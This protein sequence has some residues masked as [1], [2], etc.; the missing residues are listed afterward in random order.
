[1]DGRVPTN[2]K[3]EQLYARSQHA[4]YEGETNSDD[5]DY[6]HDKEDWLKKIFKLIVPAFIVWFLHG[7]LPLYAVFLSY[8]AFYPTRAVLID[9]MFGTK[10][11]GDLTKLEIASLALPALVAIVSLLAFYVPS[12]AFL[13]AYLPAAIIV[14]AGF[15]FAYLYSSSSPELIPVMTAITMTAVMFG[16]GLLVEANFVLAASLIGS[17]VFLIETTFY[18]SNKRDYDWLFMLC[19]F[20]FN[21]VSTI[22]LTLI[23]GLS[24]FGLLP[25][26][27]LTKPVFATIWA[28]FILAY[29]FTYFFIEL[30]AQAQEG[31]I[32]YYSTFLLSLCLV[33]GYIINPIFA[34]IGIVVFALEYYLKYQGEESY[35]TKKSILLYCTLILPLGYI[36]TSLIANP[37]V[38]FFAALTLGASSPIV[39]AI[40][41]SSPICII[42]PSSL[43]FAIYKNSKPK[44]TNILNAAILSILV[45]V[46]A[47]YI[48]APV[49]TPFALMLVSNVAIAL[50]LAIF[51]SSLAINIKLFRDITNLETRYFKILNTKNNHKR[52]II[53]LLSLLTLGVGIVLAFN[54][55]IFAATNVM[56]AFVMQTFI[57]Q[58]L[59]V[60]TSV[61]VA[62]TVWRTLDKALFNTDNEK[63]LNKDQIDSTVKIALKAL[64]VILFAGVGYFVAAILPMFAGLILPT[65]SALASAFSVLSVPGVFV[66]IITAAYA[67][68]IA[69][70]YLSPHPALL[71]EPYTNSHS[72]QTVCIFGDHKV[73]AS[74]IFNFKQYLC[75]KSYDHII[76]VLEKKNDNK[77]FDN[78]LYVKNKNTKQDLAR[79]YFNTFC[80][81]LTLTIYQNYQNSDSSYLSN[82]IQQESKDFLA[83]NTSPQSTMT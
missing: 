46:I 12:F 74:E 37:G 56:Q 33:L 72:D 65:W 13:V 51:V 42:L 50:P 82:L 60:A 16:S 58:A 52:F 26:L 57:M 83:N 11:I 55:E 61:I 69:S 59:T 80:D 47:S 38:G 40:M 4:L 14:L 29:S 34:T 31:V 54:I 66:A 53:I 62:A 41:I 75:E 3:D 27:A 24:G 32:I 1:M 17:V 23:F 71:L 67:T 8:A 10:N 70:F 15:N 78:T 63:N 35:K 21:P 36:I 81:P 79:I 19:Y 25:A 9:I 7:L 44:P 73:T 28:A 20:F 39:L 48:M 18:I 5:G 45:Y 6:N 64:G 77:R 49:G 22:A 76:F 2:W 68:N 43:L 30:N